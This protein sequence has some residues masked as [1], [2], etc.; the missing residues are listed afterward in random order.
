MR[1]LYRL[2]SGLATGKDLASND[3]IPE[4]KP[5]TLANNRVGKLA[6]TPNIA[7]FAKTACKYAAFLRLTLFRS[8]IFS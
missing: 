3:S 8:I 1:F 2:D 5:D 6:R 7:G 4:S